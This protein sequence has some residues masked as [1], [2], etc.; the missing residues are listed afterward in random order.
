MGAA[1]TAVMGAGFAE[2]GWSSDDGAGKV[3]K[4]GGAFAVT[5]DFDLP[6]GPGFDGIGAFALWTGRF[7]LTPARV[8]GL[9]WTG[10]RSTA[11][12]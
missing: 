7:G 11:G 1:S 2:L 6:A 8:G 9:V 5:A 10:L 4:L 12:E 3:R